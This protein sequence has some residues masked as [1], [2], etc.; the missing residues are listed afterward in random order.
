MWPADVANTFRLALLAIASVAI[1]S[2]VG[3]SRGV[4]TALVE[5]NPSY[6]EAGSSLRL[7]QSGR[8]WWETFED[9][10]LTRLIRQALGNNLELQ[11]VAARISQANATL[12][13]AGGRLFPQIDGEGSYGVRWTDDDSQ[14]QRETSS[15]LGALVDWE[16]DLWGR[17]RSSRE[18]RRLERDATISDWLGARLLLSV[19]VAET[20]F[21]ILEQKRQLLLLDDQIKNSQTLLELTELRFGQAQSSVVDVLQQREQLA[22]IRTRVPT[23]EGRLQQLSY[24]LD[25]LLGRAPGNGPAIAGKEIDLPSSS[26]R[27][28]GVPSDLLQ[29]RPDLVASAQRVA[30]IDQEV[31]ETIADR[32]PRL[33]LGGFVSGTGGPGIESVITNAVSSLAAP[34]FDAG[35]R[36]AEVARRQEALREALASYS[37]DYLTAVRDV[38]TAL[39]LERKQVE[40][41]TLLNQELDI[42]QKLLR[43]SHHRWGQGLTDYLP[44]LTAVITVQRLE[45]ELIT[46]HREILSARVALHRAIGG[47]METELER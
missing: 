39:V 29:N 43:E 20:Y 40:R 22:A 26:L 9:R 30:A 3:G 12:R 14:D 38:E 11:A 17:L 16:V 8:P 34:I 7:K 2:C 42:A 6:R 10:A 21:E 33:T 23:V 13:Q 35:I 36:K 18:A 46:S 25:V 4:V 5:A 19:A 27:T 32:L 1:A 24:A 28:V 37:H 41:M 31:A 45:R 44:V 15:N 47:P